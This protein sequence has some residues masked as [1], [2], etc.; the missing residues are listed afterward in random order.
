MMTELRGLQAE[1]SL[2]RASLSLSDNSGE[3]RAAFASTMAHISNLELH[4]ATFDFIFGW[5]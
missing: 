5:K 4:E 1:S 2:S 3:P